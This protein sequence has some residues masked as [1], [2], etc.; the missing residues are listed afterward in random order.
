METFKF[1]EISG[2]KFLNWNL[3]AFEV[4]FN[5]GI[6]FRKIK[7]AAKPYKLESTTIRTGTYW[8]VI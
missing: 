2:I 1:D 3:M 7:K 5:S 4:K 8:G 6:L